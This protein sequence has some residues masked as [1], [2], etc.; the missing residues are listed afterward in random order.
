MTKTSAICCPAAAVREYL[1]QHVAGNS[2]GLRLVT[3][4]QETSHQYVHGGKWL[5][6]TETKRRYGYDLLRSR[7]NS[8]L[9]A[10][11]RESKAG[12]FRL[13]KLGGC[14]RDPYGSLWFCTLPS[15]VIPCGSDS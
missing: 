4:T 9:A 7:W 13:F 8:L 14:G 11:I 6:T 1:V 5:G 3:V 15:S 2:A 10:S 12:M